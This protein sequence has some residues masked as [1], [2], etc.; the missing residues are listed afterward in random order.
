MLFFLVDPLMLGYLAGYLLIGIVVF[1]KNIFVKLLDFDFVLLL[2]FSLVSAA[3]YTT[4]MTSG[5]QFV[6][7]YGLFPPFFYIIGKKI[8]YNTN[9]YHEIFYIFFALSALFSISAVIS[10]SLNLIEGGFKQIDRTIPMFWNGKDMKATAMGAYL[11][12]N[13]TIPGLLLN[14]KQKLNKFFMLFAMALYVITLLAVFRLGSRTQLGITLISIVVSLFFIIP[15][16]SKKN[17]LKFIFTLI[18]IVAAFLL[19]FPIDLEADYFSVLG[20]RLQESDNAGSAGGRTERWTKSIEYL[21]SHPLGWKVEAFGFSHNMWFDVARYSGLIAFILL[22]II[23][24]R[25]YFKTYKAIKLNKDAL[26]INSQ[27]LV[28]SIASF[29]IFFVEPIM[30]GLF[31]L[32]TSYCVFQG[33]IHSYLE[34]Y[35]KT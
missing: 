1:K 26:L 21:Y 8:V 4:H 10:V 18:V 34:K 24:I 32:F 33:M 15:N 22:I 11:T 9:S 19:F 28:Y 29:L 16:Q 12:Y 30:D 2:V 3:V 27:I 31:F 23:T 20:S 13:M 7:I 35:K 17:N 5:I 25:F 6:I 14:Y